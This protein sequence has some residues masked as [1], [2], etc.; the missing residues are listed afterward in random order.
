MLIFREFFNTQSDQNILP[1]RIKL[2]H[3]F[4]IFSGELAY[5]LDCCWCPLKIS[6]S[7]FSATFF[8]KRLLGITKKMTRFNRFPW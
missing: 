6:R 1:K 3:I 8:F 5:A 7:Y 4:K 2:H